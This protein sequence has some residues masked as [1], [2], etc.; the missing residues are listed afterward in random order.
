VKT[1]LSLAVFLGLTLV[2]FQN[3]SDV[4][5]SSSSNDDNG[6]GGPPAVQCDPGQVVDSQGNCRNLIDRVTTATVAPTGSEVDILLVI[7]NSGSMAADNRRL[8]SRM[9]DFV[10]RLQNSG[11]SWQVCYTTTG[12]GPYSDNGTTYQSE[13]GRALT[14]LSDTGSNT[15]EIV[16][17]PSSP[18]N[19]SERFTRSLGQFAGSSAN[20]NERGIVAKTLAVERTDNS[21][22]FRTGAILST[23]IISDEDEASCGGRCQRSSDEATMTGRGLTNYTRQYRALSSENMPETLVQ[24]VRARF[25]ENK[26]FVA[27]SIVIRSNPKDLTC[28]HAQDASHPAFYGKVYESLSVLTGG[29]VGSICSS[30]YAAELG[31]IAS[32]IEESLSSITLDCA[33]YD[34]KVSVSYSPAAPNSQTYKVEGNKLIFTPKLTEGTTVT[35]SYQCLQLEAN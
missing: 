21:S 1:R 17:S 10:N 9:A 34:K 7:D 29:V 28:Y 22:C 19:L 33:P 16:L 26:K 23:I 12:V 6:G 14:W 13:D 32:R 3:C 30:D 18:G 35:A 24:R 27:N 31:Q 25:G 5:F 4:S 15:N 2:S 11:L 8:A 20:G